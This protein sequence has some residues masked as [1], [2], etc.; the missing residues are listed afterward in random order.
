MT[1]TLS[2]LL[3]FLTGLTSLDRD[4]IK[5]DANFPGGNVL[6]DSISGHHV[7]IRPDLRDTSTDWF[8]WYFAAKPATAGMVHFHLSGNNYLTNA[9]PAYSI[10]QGKTWHWLGRDFTADSFRFEFKAGQEVRFSMGMPY[11]QA[12]FDAFL[13]PY[14]KNVRLE[15]LCQ[16][17]KGRAIE[18]LV[19]GSASASRKVLITARHHACEMMTNYA[20]EGFISTLLSKDKMMTRLRNEVEFWIIP[21]MDKDGVEDGDQGKNRKPKDHNRDYNDES[22]YCSTAALRAQV[23]AWSQ[24]NLIAALDLHCPW[25]KGD[26]NEHIYLVGSA[27]SRIAAEQLRLIQM[28]SRHN[29]GEVKFDAEKGFVPFGTSWNTAK[30]FVQGKSFSAWA[31]ELEGTRLSTTIEIP[32]SLNNGQLLT[33]DNLRVFGRDMAFALGEY[34]GI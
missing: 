4:E 33:P 26:L 22:L 34:L 30:N 20:L 32:Y 28:L 29:Q 5:I 16:T 19:I 27:N 13:K 6:V 12:Q 24:G 23:P 31:S 17:P 8:Y 11:T 25:I 9:G 1:L 18:K 2:L 10:D 14:R 3:I 15:T 21:F 7:Y